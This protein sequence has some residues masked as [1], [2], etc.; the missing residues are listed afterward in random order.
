MTYRKLRIAWSVAWGTVAVLLCLLWVRSYWRQDSVQGFVTSTYEVGISSHKGQGSLSLY[1]INGYR[2]Y[3]SGWNWSS[4]EVSGRNPDW[5]FSYSSSFWGFTI[6]AP[7]IVLMA[8]IGT[9]AAAPWLPFKRFSLR[10]SLIATT[11]IAV[12][13]GLIVWLR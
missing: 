3:Y 6:K 1:A 11:L 8:C 9:L 10:T 7:Q 12:V 4:K 2:T 13:L 5:G